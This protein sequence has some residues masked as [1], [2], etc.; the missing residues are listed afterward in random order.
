MAEVANETTDPLPKDRPVNG[1]ATG[2]TSCLGMDD[3]DLAGRSTRR[4]TMNSSLGRLRSS[5]LVASTL[6]LLGGCASP[7]RIAVQ[8]AEP[9]LVMEEF[10]AGVS[11]GEGVFV[12]SWT[13][14]ER[15]FRVVIAGFWDGKE[16][17]LVEDFDYA[18]GEKDR[19][20]WRLQSQGPGTFT[21]TR[22]DVVG[23]ARVWTEDRRV[24]LEYSVELGGWTVEFADILALR[25]DGT[26]LN[27]A[28][29]AKWGL[30]IGRV[31]LVLRKRPA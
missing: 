21:G 14:T 7:P 31:E 1:S 20:T 15:R 17:T 10:F 23:Q 5:L 22:E 4:S 9:P 8:P 3:G 16:L 24:R 2:V 30:R 19:K 26:L 13:G 6:S 25:A 18:D 12:N 11:D 28:T 29:V 27:R